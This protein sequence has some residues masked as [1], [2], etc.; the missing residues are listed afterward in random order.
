MQVGQGYALSGIDFYDARSGH[1]VNTDG[2][3]FVTTD[4][5]AFDKVGVADSEGSFYGV[6]SDGPEDVRVTGG[7]GL[8]YRYTGEWT[9]TNLGD[10]NLRDV[11]IGDGTGYTVGESGTVFEY[12]SGTWSEETTETGQNLRAVET[13]DPNVAVGASSTVITD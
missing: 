5:T 6:D 2:N 3:A 9:N 11:E 12:D 10:P 13:G 1:V 8:A 7:G 4:G